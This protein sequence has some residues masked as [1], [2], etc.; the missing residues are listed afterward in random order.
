MNGLKWRAC[1]SDPLPASSVNTKS[2]LVSPIDHMIFI[3]A[4][5]NVYLVSP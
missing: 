4:N 5:R 3:L 1:L 2:L